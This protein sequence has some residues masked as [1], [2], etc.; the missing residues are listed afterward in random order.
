MTEFEKKVEEIKEK[1]SPN[2]L[3]IARVPLKTKQRFIAIA[4]EEF[5]EDYGMLLKKLVE[6]YDGFYPTGH[7]EIEAK[8]DILANEIALIQQK[9]DNLEEKKEIKTLGGVKIK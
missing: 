4:N 7:E 1:T 2:K 5:E 6:V 3:Y 8:I 9:L